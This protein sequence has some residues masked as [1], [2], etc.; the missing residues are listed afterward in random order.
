MYIIGS[1]H[2]TVLIWAYGVN[3]TLERGGAPDD[4]ESITRNLFNFAF[5]GASGKVL[6]FICLK[7]AK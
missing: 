3:R 6:A 1:T 5:D 2:D 7:C 4:G